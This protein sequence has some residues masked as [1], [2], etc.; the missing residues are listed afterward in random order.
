MDE[1]CN[2]GFVRWHSN[3]VR[4][5]R[6][7]RAFNQRTASRCSSISQCKVVGS[8]WFDRHCIFCFVRVHVSR[9]AVLSICT[10]LQHSVGRFAYAAICGWGWCHCADCCA[11]CIEIWNETDCRNWSHQHV[12]RSG[13]YR[14]LWSRYCLLGSGHH[15]HGVSCQRS[16]TRYFASN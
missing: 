15:Q 16:G 4:S 5:I 1:R 12:Y 6:E 9:N 3:F 11:T 13:H 7:A 14:I 10:R 2:I 8:Y